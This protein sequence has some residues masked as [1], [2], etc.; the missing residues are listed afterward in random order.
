VEAAWRA[1]PGMI[2]DA[3]TYH[4]PR[5]IAGRQ[6]IFVS[7]LRIRD[8]DP[9]D[10]QFW[11]VGDNLRKGAASNAVQILMEIFRD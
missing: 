6:E 7:R 11:A 2:Y 4:T 10:L 1:M 5:E 9:H 8:D 3:Q